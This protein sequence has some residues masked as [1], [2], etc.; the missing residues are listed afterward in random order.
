M[1]EEKKKKS[2]G[3]KLLPLWIILGLLVVIVGTPV[4]LVALAYD[5]RR[6]VTDYGETTAQ[7]VGSKAFLRGLNNI[8]DDG[9]LDVA[10]TKKD[11][12]GVIATVTKEFTNIDGPVE[13]IYILTKGNKVTAYIEI[14]A[15][16]FKTRLS[17][18]ST[19]ETTDDDFVMGIN[20]FKL[21]NLSLNRETAVKVLGWF[22][23]KLN[24]EKDFDLFVLDLKNWQIRLSKEVMFDSLKKG[25]DQNE[26]VKDVFT[27]L[28]NENLITF[29]TSTNN[30]IDMKVD[31][32]KL[33]NNDK[34]TNDD[35]HLFINKPS[36]P[37][38]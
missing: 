10:I 13:N 24:D 32:K 12:N 7:E 17:V 35:D 9:V 4:V 22:G 21:G 5:G 18:E 34:L 20:K 16:K 37:Y 30:L 26:F 33:Q 38:N 8:D 23:V 25:S 11:A 36:S 31:L 2:I 3:R 14:S 27:I 19:I 1:A 6:N 28:E 29:D 15:W